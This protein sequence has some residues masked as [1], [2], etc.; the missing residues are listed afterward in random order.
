MCYREFFVSLF[1]GIL[2]V[3][4]CTTSTALLVLLAVMFP[5]F[6][7]PWSTVS[8]LLLFCF[9]V[10]IDVTFSVMATPSKR[11]LWVDPN[12]VGIPDNHTDDATFLREM[13]TNMN[14]RTYTYIEAVRG[15]AVLVQQ[16]SLVV[17]FII[18]YVSMHQS[19]VSAIQIIVLCCVTSWLLHF[20]YRR[21]TTGQWLPAKTDIQTFI[22]IYGFAFGVSP[23]LA[24][25]TRTVSTD[26]IYTMVAALLLLS[27]GVHDYGPQAMVVS[28]A[29]SLNAAFGASV[30]LA[31]RLPSSVDAFALIICAVGIF[32]LW[33]VMRSVLKRRL[34]SGFVCITIGI[35]LSVVTLLGLLSKFWLGMFVWLVGMIAVVCPGILV[36]LQ[37]CKTTIHGPWD[38][39]VL[40]TEPRPASASKKLD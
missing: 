4:A 3:F 18:I 20:W 22:A 40:R 29:F 36:H 37:K 5:S 9:V 24:T 15:S 7:I 2:A 25:L 31:S 23:I 32:G 14:L 30:C 33:P 26:S 8:N 16:I 34:P 27:L 35:V 38:E 28:E 11:I 6:R 13:K 39:A 12:N 19:V 17:F 1:L 21:L 10:L